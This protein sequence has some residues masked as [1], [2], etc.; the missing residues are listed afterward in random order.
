MIAAARFSA[1]SCGYKE[2][3]RVKSLLKKYGLPTEIEFDKARVFE[4]LKMDK[5]KQR[6]EMNYI[7]LEK[8]GRGVVKSI[9]LAQLEKM[10]QNI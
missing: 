1:E 5:K 2:P 7:L 10:L 6:N 3:D 8:T 4:V 9:P